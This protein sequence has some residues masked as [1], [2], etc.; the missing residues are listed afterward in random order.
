M[1]RYMNGD[2]EA[3][4]AVA[5]RL[6][7]DL[8]RILAGEAPTA[9]ELD[10]APLLDGW[11]PAATLAPTIAG[12]V[13]GHPLLGTRPC[14]ETTPLYVIDFDRGWARTWN[15]FYRLSASADERAVGGHG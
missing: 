2:G 3:L 7:S 10:V 15:R 13:H 8:K 1:P 9:A 12:A 14:I 5:A 6:A 4:A 11:M